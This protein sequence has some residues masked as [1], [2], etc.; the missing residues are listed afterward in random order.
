[1][2]MQWNATGTVRNTASRPDQRWTRFTRGRSIGTKRSSFPKMRAPVRTCTA[3]RTIA[4]LA[5]HT[6]NAIVVEK[7][8]VTMAVYFE[9]TLAR[10]TTVVTPDLKRYDRTVSTPEPGWPLRRIVVLP[11]VLFAAVSASVFTLA[12]LHPA[13]PETAAATPTKLGDPARGQIIFKETCGGCHG[14]K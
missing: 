11:L 3:A 4:A 10:K 13:R 7:T 8:D 14:L 6:L 2:K 1:M 9:A 5:N 12:K